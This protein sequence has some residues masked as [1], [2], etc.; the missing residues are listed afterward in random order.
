MKKIVLLFLCFILCG[1]EKLTE[2]EKIMKEEDYIIVDV[3]SEA[4]YKQGHIVDSINIPYG[5]ISKSNLDKDQV[6]F[7]YCRS[8][9]RSEIAYHTL[10]SLGYDVYSLGK[11]ISK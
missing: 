3:R 9:N 8:G 6:V 11:S 10:K 5:E 1:C 2:Y 4:E 7:V